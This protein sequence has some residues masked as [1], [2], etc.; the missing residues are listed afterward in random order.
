MFKHPIEKRKNAATRLKS[1]TWWERIAAPMRHWKIPR[2]PTPKLVPNTGKYVSKNLYGQP[3]SE[4][5]R[6]MTWKM[7]RRRLR[8]AQNTPAGWFGTVLPL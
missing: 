8:T 7:M 6:M 3:H 4:R 1:S 2:A 5:K